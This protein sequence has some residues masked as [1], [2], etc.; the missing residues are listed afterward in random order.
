[1]INKI[2]GLN[3]PTGMVVFGKTRLEFL[4]EPD[5]EEWQQLMEYLSHCRHT[6][7]R[8]IADARMTGRK[9]F[10]DSEVE[11]YISQLQLNFSDLNAAE[12]LEH[13]E[14][15]SEGLTDAHHQVVANA[16]DDNQDRAKWL[17][18]AEDEGLT[19]KELKAS[20]AGSR[21]I[22]DSEVKRRTAGVATI[23]GVRS[24]FHIWRGQVGED[25]KKW[26]IDRKQRLLAEIA[27]I[28]ALG[29]ELVEDIA[30]KGGAK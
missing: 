16:L 5:W 2:V 24:L 19:P 26:D 13:M 17:K 23:E 10:G 7:L 15:R 3:L 9:I 4:R 21:V 6:S 8:W 20:I 28:C 22:K 14:T 27:E 11:A 25:W 1:M 18:T 30:A 12:A 29:E